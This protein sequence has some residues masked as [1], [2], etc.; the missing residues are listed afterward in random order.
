MLF[1]N[2]SAEQEQGVERPQR[3]EN[4]AGYQRVGEGLGRKIQQKQQRRDHHH[5]REVRKNVQ[6]GG[7]GA[8]TGV[9]LLHQDHTVGS[10]AGHRA[11][12]HQKQLMVEALEAFP[13]GHPDIQVSNK[14][15]HYAENDNGPNVVFNIVDLNGGHAGHDHQIEGEAGDPVH[16]VV[17]D[18]HPVHQISSAQA[19]H[20]ELDQHGGQGSPK[21]VE[22][23]GN[24]VGEVGKDAQQTH[25]AEGQCV[26]QG[27]KAC[28]Q[29]EFIHGFAVGDFILFC[30]HRRF[31]QRAGLAD[32]EVALPFADV[33]IQ[34]T[35][36]G[37]HHKADGGQRK[38]EAAIACKLGGR[39]VGEVNVPAQGVAGTLTVGQ[40]QDQTA[41]IGNDLVA[42]PGQQEQNQ[43]DGQAYKSLQ[44]I[45][46]ALQGTKFHHLGAVC[47]MGALFCF[48]RHSGKADGQTVIGDGL[49]QPVI[50]HHKAKL[51]ADHIYDQQNR[52]AQKGR[53]NQ[54]FAKKR[55]SS[56]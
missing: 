52:A 12:A 23:P 5:S 10:G 11:E 44:H 29:G 30:L 33:D 6:A 27:D 47:L 22:A 17:V 38:T 18:I 40:G 50:Y 53:R 3:K 2:S 41:N 34:N 21:E 28:L 45:A 35:E 19:L 31:F 42:V 48:Q 43:G 55:H 1:E 20:H 7:G 49:H 9:D 37:C 51:L 4:A 26:S 46:A 25:K 39:G 56:P 15:A 16:L 13:G 8:Q 32:G 24:A 14:R 54:T 36:D